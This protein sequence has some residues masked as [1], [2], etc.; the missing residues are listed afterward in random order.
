MRLLRH[1]RVSLS[2]ALAALACVLGPAWAQDAID[3]F[4]DPLPEEAP[5]ASSSEPAEVSSE[6]SEGT[7]ERPAQTEPV[8][9]YVVPIN[10]GID[11]PNQF[12][13]RRGAKQAMEDQADV[14]ILE[15]DTPGGR[16]DVMLEMMEEL[17]AYEGLTIVFVNDEAMS[18]GAFIAFAADEIWYAPDA[19]IG[20]AAPV[21]AT[22]E[23]IPETLLLKY[24]S[25]INAKARA[26]SETHPYK[27]Q[28]IRA[29]SEPEYELKIGDKVLKPA[30]EL[31][32]LTAAEALT[33]YGVPPT[34]LFGEGQAES[35]DDLLQQRF[36]AGNYTVRNFE[37]TWS[38][39]LA[40]YLTPIAPLLLALAILAFYLEFQ[41][42]G[43]GIFGISGLV[44]LGVFFASNYVAGL[45]GHEP[46]L[47][48]VLGLVLV[49]LEI[50]LMP[51]ILIFAGLGLLLMLGALVWSLAD[52]W[53][54]APGE[55]P[56][57]EMGDLTSAAMQVALALLLAAVAGLLLWRFLPKS[58]HNRLILREAVTGT[59]PRPAGSVAV[60]GEAT[61]S[62]PDLGS[63]GRVIRDLHPVGE[64]EIGGKRYQATV[65][66]G[67]LGKGTAIIVVAYR[68]FALL[69]EE[70]RS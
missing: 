2:L 65:G 45:A 1:H 34:A 4:K 19:I 31:L 24:K 62:L 33:R 14:L 30:G 12:I 27:Y 7:P 60:P 13:F 52:V 63:K 46:A 6:P 32:T 69:V 8:T 64:V 5:P 59:S 48:F 40:K 3:A 68:N 44:L 70:D 18:A 21:A 49:L 42:P 57:I 51:G 26:L 67:S 38:E 16:G 22:G 28:V 10:E 54:G 25:Y 43:F 35:V 55:L 47:L 58:V 15:V 39:E 20:A 11:K 37:I 56:Q 41:T 36:G 66:V 53:P 29:M 17:D 9:V 61:R 23:D 50:L